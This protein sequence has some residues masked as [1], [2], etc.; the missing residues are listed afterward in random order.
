[1][2]DD[3]LKAV[4]LFQKQYRGSYLPLSSLGKEEIRMLCQ[5]VSRHLFSL[6][7]LI[8]IIPPFLFIEYNFHDMSLFS[9]GGRAKPDL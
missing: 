2:A 3:D 6:F 4:S 8:S 1:M 7:L 5:A 9:W